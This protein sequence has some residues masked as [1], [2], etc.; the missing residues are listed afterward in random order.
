MSRVLTSLAIGVA[1]TLAMLVTNW[2]VVP[3]INHVLVEPY[4]TP[5]LIVDLVLCFLSR[6]HSCSPHFI[7]ATPM[8]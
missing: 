2:E 3:P 1:T 7:V 5:G 6:L 8:D 4:S